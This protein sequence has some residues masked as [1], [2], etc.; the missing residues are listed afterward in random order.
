MLPCYLSG[1]CTVVHVMC[2]PCVFLCQPVGGHFVLLPSLC[3]YADAGASGLVL[4]GRCQWLAFLLAMPLLRRRLQRAHHESI[5]R[6]QWAPPLRPRSYVFVSC[7]SAW[8]PQ[9]DCVGFVAFLAVA[10]HERRTLSAIGATVAG[11]VLGQRVSVL[12]F[13]QPKSCEIE[14][15]LPPCVVCVVPWWVWRRRETVV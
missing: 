6:G 3:G 2:S 10:V 15:G 13:G 5:G 9:R 7:R 1:V 11:V 12:V 8:A 14:I 4:L